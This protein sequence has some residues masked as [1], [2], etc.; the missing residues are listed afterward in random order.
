MAK[1]DNKPRMPL[2]FQLKGVELLEACLNQPRQ[3]IA[4][5][6]VFQFDIKL[7]HKISVETKIVAVVIFVD[8]YN[9]QRDVKL[10]SISASCIFELVNLP[11]F[12][13]TKKNNIDLPEEFLTAINSISIS[14]ARGIMFNQFR[15]TFLHH[16]FLP[17]VDPQSF[18]ILK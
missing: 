10:G 11:D 16:A 4:D 9:E 12:I 15:G 14:T 7:E 6:K 3:P 8:L 17:L 1:K 18:E 2:N 5:L 13:D